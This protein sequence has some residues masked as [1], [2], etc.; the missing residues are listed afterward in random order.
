MENEKELDIQLTL[1][2]HKHEIASLKHRMDDVEK[3]Q[4]EIYELTNAVNK[5]AVS[6]EFMAKEQSEQGKRLDTLEKEPAENAKYYKRTIISCVITTLVGA[7]IGALIA[8][9]IH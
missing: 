4:D 5:L 2:S 8:L 6:V 9:L 7:V 1:N 3:K